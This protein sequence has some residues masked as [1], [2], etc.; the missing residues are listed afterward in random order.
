MVDNGGTSIGKAGAGSLA[1][2]LQAQPAAARVHKVGQR[3]TLSAIAAR[4][5]VRL[6]ALMA[7]NPQ[8]E[9]SHWIYPGDKIKIPSGDD[10]AGPVY[11]KGKAVKRSAAPSAPAAKAP[12]I[13]TDEVAAPAPAAT[14]EAFAPPTA[15]A[16]QAPA[17][18][19]AVQQQAAAPV[20][21]QL[22]KPSLLS[23]IGE[24][25]EFMI[26]ASPVFG[27]LFS[28]ICLAF[29]ALRVAYQALIKHEKIDWTKEGLHALANIVGGFLPV[30]GALGNA[31]LNAYYNEA[32]VLGGVN[33]LFGPPKGSAV[34]WAE[35]KVTHLF[36][37]K[38]APAT[39]S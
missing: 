4:Y 12:V 29:Q 36:D 26:R 18:P 15:V 14:R 13:S 17:Q 7:A 8:I 37:G 27:Q 6:D 25:A 16:P 2:D 1:V 3:E 21:Q 33:K 38:A 9:D 23:A 11:A 31:G 30:Y 34:R 39:Q 19:A 24:I 5:H 35:D 22:A 32:E 20:D 10:A 28:W